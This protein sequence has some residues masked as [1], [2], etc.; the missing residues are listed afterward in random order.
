MPSDVLKERVQEDS[1]P[2]DIWLKKRYITLTDR[3]QYDYRWYRQNS[4]RTW[5]HKRRTI[6][7]KNVDS[8]GKLIM[9]P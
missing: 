3:Y 8:D 7:V 2:Y 5:S 4:D 6:A 1:V 9:A